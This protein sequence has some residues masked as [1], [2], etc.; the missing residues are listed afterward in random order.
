MWSIHSST[1]T[2]LE[3]RKEFYELLQ[4]RL[5]FVTVTDR[6]KGIRVG[7]TCRPTRHLDKHY[8]EQL[9]EFKWL[10]DTIYKRHRPIKNYSQPTKLTKWITE[11]R[12]IYRFINYLRKYTIFSCSS[13]TSN[14]TIKKVVSTYTYLGRYRLRWER[15]RFVD[16]YN[17]L[18]NHRLLSVGLGNTDY[19]HWD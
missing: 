1:E 10:L 19:G 3:P 2:T 5:E 7:R 15:K 13:Y 4:Q 12:S 9:R 11:V 14:S 6:G 18:F 16:R 17:P 8:N